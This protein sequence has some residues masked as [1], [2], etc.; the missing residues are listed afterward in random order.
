MIVFVDTSVW[1]DFLNGF[2]KPTTN[3]LEEL[4]NN[5]FVVIGDLILLEILQGLKDQKEFLKVKNF[6]L[7][8]ECYQMLNTELAIHAAKNYRH[9]QSMG[10]TVHKTTDNIIATF[11]IASDF[12]LLHN[13][14]DF[15]PFKDHLKL[16]TVTL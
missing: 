16:K 15:L 6:L 5:E 10:I 8:L 1:I 12:I 13:D 2:D 7:D 14:K 9:L 4:L 3:K 11:C